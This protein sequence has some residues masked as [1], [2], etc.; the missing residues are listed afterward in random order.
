MLKTVAAAPMLSTKDKTTT[1]VTT[2]VFTR[3]RNA[4]RSSR[5]EW[6]LLR[7]GLSSRVVKDRPR[8]GSSVREQAPGKLAACV[9]NTAADG[10]RRRLH[11]TRGFYRSAAFHAT[12]D[13]KTLLP[14]K[15]HQGTEETGSFFA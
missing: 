9:M 12:L 8:S 14:G 4:C 6:I 5:I 3:D 13:D 10:S 15:L 11:E 1:A 2:G 7:P